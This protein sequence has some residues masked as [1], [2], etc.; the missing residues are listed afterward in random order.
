M[1]LGDPFIRHTYI[2]RTVQRDYGLRVDLVLLEIP[3]ML[4]SNISNI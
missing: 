1:A 4:T 2:V 3:V